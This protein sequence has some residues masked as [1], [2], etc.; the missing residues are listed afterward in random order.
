MVCCPLRTWWYGTRIYPNLSFS[1][2]LCHKSFCVSHCHSWLSRDANVVVDLW[3]GESHVGSSM[4]SKRDRRKPLYL[5]LYTAVIKLSVCCYKS[6]HFFTWWRNETLMRRII[7]LL[8]RRRDLT[9]TFNYSAS[10]LQWLTGMHVSN[11]HTW[12]IY[13][14]KSFPRNLQEVQ[15]DT[16]SRLTASLRL[17]PSAEL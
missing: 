15:L 11:T 2:V 7:L 10:I 3:W 4:I 14:N 16:R 17:N 1:F 8:L 9:C 6:W 13:R 5:L 12:T